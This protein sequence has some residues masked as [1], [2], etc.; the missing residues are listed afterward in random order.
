VETG[1]KKNA[2]VDHCIST[3]RVPEAATRGALAQGARGVFRAS[4]TSVLS[5]ARILVADDDPLLLDAVTDALS[6]LGARVTRAATGAELVDELAA[7]GPFDLVIT[8]VA[9]PWMSGLTAMR[10]ARTAGLGTAVI[11]MTARQ[12]EQI[13]AQVRALGQNA[14]LLRKPFGLDE[15]E[16]IASKLIAR[17][18]P[19]PAAATDL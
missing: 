13:P 7:A 19:V 2:S 14:V 3:T 10:A 4:D 9:M 11:V 15:L 17:L 16:K 6:G 18:K 5:D 1:R 8:D 12:D